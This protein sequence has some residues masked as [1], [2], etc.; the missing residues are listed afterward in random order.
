MLSSVMSKLHLKGNSNKV[1]PMFDADI[2]TIVQCQIYVDSFDSIS[3][4][5]MDYTVSMMLALS[6]MQRD[7]AYRYDVDFFE[8]D[9]D[10]MQKIW[11][12]DLYF[13]NEKKASFHQVMNPNQMMRLYPDGRL[14]YYARLSLTLSCPMN[15]RN[16][17]FDRQE[18]A[19]KIE[20][21]GFDSEKL[22]LEWVTDDVPVDVNRDIQLPQFP[23]RVPRE[24]TL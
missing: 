5:S 18:C 24:W 15:L 16:Y 10:N 1:P 23:G 12:P 4:A 14:E 22:I 8:I 19:L 13:P 6:W 20:S 7:L 3:E 17:P 21:F 9:N 11:I 2:P